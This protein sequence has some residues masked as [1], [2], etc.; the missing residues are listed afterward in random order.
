M[1]ISGN[2][3]RPVVVDGYP[4][5]NCH[6]VAEAKKGVNPATQGQFGAQAGD[7]SAASGEPTQ[8]AATSGLSPAT[9]AARYA[10]GAWLDLSA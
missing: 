8:A 4:C 1:T 3:A 10:P 7:G 2:Y 6:Q 9:N 5:W